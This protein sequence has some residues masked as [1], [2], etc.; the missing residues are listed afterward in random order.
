LRVW[1][2]VR[3][4]RLQRCRIFDLDRVEF[5]PRDGRP[6]QGFYV[7][8]A[9]SWINVIP[10]TPDRTV[11]L[12]RQF[13]FGVQQATLEIPGGMCDPDESPRD[14]ARRELLEETGHSSDRL[15]PLGW[16]YPNPAVQTNRCYTFLA[17]D[18]RRVSDPRPDPNESFEHVEVPLDQIPRLIADGEIN[19]AL[20]VAAFQLLQARRLEPS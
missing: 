9:P 11:L 15:E 13:R 8:D 14:A 2:R 3:S 7:I 4:H 18:V 6:P 1:R 16:V 10:L 5:D 20:V 19:H 12:V 17:L